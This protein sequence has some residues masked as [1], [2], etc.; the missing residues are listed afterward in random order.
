[1]SDD[2]AGEDWQRV[3]MLAATVEDHELLDPELTVERLLLAP[4]SRRGRCDRTRHP[5]IARFAGAAGRRWKTFFWRLERTELSDM[6]DD[7][8]KIVVTCEFC[9]TRYMFS[10]DELKGSKLSNHICVGSRTWR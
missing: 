8:G 3:E 7:N 1:M 5:A 6:R 9:A 4:L 2:S 10:L